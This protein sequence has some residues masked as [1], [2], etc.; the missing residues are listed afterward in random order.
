M[1]TPR[2]HDAG[3]DLFGGGILADVVAGPGLQPLD[4]VAPLGERREKDDR[5]PGGP[6][7]QAPAELEALH[8]GQH[9]IE[10]CQVGERFVAAGEGLGAGRGVDDAVAPV[11]EPP[12]VE[13]REVDV[14]LDVEQRMSAIG[15]RRVYR[16]FGG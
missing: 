8:V 5:Q 11:G 9:D 7:L 1:R 16:G 15:H 6:L 10:Q 13:F 4:G 14:I 12:D 3:V 2:R